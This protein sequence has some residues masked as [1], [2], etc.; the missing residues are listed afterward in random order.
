MALERKSRPSWLIDYITRPESENGRQLNRAIYK[1]GNV[2][3]YNLDRRELKQVGLPIIRDARARMR[4]LEQHG[5]TDSPAYR[6]MKKLN[7]K[8]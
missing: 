2:G 3:V 6:H 1:I 4:Q 5:L 7:I 8:R